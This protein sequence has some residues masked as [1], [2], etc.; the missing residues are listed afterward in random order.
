MIPLLWA[1]P[2]RAGP[3]FSA[4]AT[5]TKVTSGDIVTTPAW[6]WGGS[7]GDYD[8]DGWQD[9]FVGSSAS[10]RNFL[11]HNDR[12]GTFTRIGDAAI[13]KSPSNQHGSVW[14][15]YDNDGDLDLFVTA[16]NPEVTTN[17]L[18][19]NNGDGT[20]SWTD[21][22]MSREPFERGFHSPSWGDYDNDGFIDLYIAG[23]DDYN[24][25]FHNNGDGTF[26]KIGSHVLV[27]DQVFHSEA[28]NWVDYDSDGDVDLFVSNVLISMSP[29]RANVLYRNDGGGVFARVTDSGLSSRDESTFSSCW[30]DYDNDG[31]QDLFLVNSSMNSLYHH[32]GNGT[33]IRVS[34][35][36]PRDRIR[37]SAIFDSC[38]WGDYDNDGFIDL[39]VGMADLAF[40]VLSV[41]HNFLY[42]NNGDGTFAKVTDSVVVTDSTRGGA[43]Q[44]WV[45]YDNDG[46]LDLFVQN[47]GFAPEPQKNAL[48]HNEGNG[49]AWLNVKLVGTVSNRS[50]IGAKVWV[51]AFFRGAN[52]RQL[53]EIVG[54]DGQNIEQSLN[55][56]FGLAD[57]TS[58]DTLRVEWPSGIV[59]E[60][61]DVAP[62]QFLTITE[63]LEQ[64]L[65]FDPLPDRSFGEPP[66]TVSASASSGLPVSF[67]ASGS[68]A[69][70]GD[71]V[72]LTGVGLCTLTASQAGDEA[73]Q[74]A[75][76]VSR[77][78]RVLFEFAGFRP[79]VADPP[80]LNR[81]NAG[82]V[83][84]ITFELWG[85]PGPGVL[86]AGGP[87]V[88]RVRCG[89]LAP[90]T[91]YEP[92]ASPGAS[93]LRY[94]AATGR[95]AFPWRT[96]K[97]W[98]GSCRELALP[99][100]D[101]SVHRAYFS[102]PGR[103]GSNGRPGRR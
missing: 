64:G 22:A 101:G 55:A 74:P 45:D 33:F 85:K 32:E 66:F 4:G 72:S 30:G 10:N 94:Q 75:P 76:E 14:G 81:A 52:R 44:S 56:E 1:Q 49:N 38:A 82:R 69:V 58:I 98:A 20:F 13:P 43:T 73:Y 23:H 8:D 71:Q 12:D 92:A 42:R 89:T 87:V 40:P 67:T 11:Y 95:Y 15:D 79:P 37:F 28:R 47:G 16:G 39:T 48:Y 57:A 83:V 91:G 103:P 96:Q 100:I 68:C 61:H 51:S 78:F 6:Y 90:E 80:V 9:L 60:L 93:A 86:E 36:I 35:A 5:F 34:S 84:P 99:L 41:D 97:R 63:R 29:F 70:S 19:R 31:L 54:G 2:G 59:E 50:A 102:F 53:R 65:L 18:Y 24:R 77:D 7:W 88:R 17:M 62:R 26:T 21:T 3:E 46:F 27:D 25:L